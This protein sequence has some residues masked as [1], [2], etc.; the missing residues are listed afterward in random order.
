MA[1]ME[2]TK[3]IQ[4]I[5]LTYNNVLYIEIWVFRYAKSISEVYFNLQGHFQGQ[6]LDNFKM[7]AMEVTKLIQIILLTVQ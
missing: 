1:A 7:A 3:L 6:M 2:V 4:I 5:L